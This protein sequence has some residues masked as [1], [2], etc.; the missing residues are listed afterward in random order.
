MTFCP[1]KLALNS[2]IVFFPNYKH[3]YVSTGYPMVPLGILD[4][5]APVWNISV[6][7]QIGTSI[8]QIGTC[9]F[10]FDFT[11][12]TSNSLEPI[13]NFNHVCYGKDP[14]LLFVILMFWYLFSGFH[15]LW[16]LSYVFYQFVFL[17]VLFRYFW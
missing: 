14:V 2:K 8:R 10:F 13:P 9:V 7:R 1:I 11:Y 3:R 12:K 5:S 16:L 15:F 4:T 6:P 17:Q